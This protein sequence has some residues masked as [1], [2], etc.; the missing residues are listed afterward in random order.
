M[1]QYFDRMGP[2]GSS[3]S[4]KQIENMKE[5]GVQIKAIMQSIYMS[6]LPEEC[7]EVRGELYR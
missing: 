6:H 1:K 7:S 2:L 5:N 3:L 4:A